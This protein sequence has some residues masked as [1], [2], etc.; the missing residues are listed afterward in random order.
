MGSKTCAPFVLNLLRNTMQ[1][2]DA[3][4]KKVQRNYKKCSTGK[5]EDVECICVMLCYSKNQASKSST[6]V[7]LLLLMVTINNNMFS[8]CFCALDAAEHHNLIF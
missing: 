3:N 8:I 2:D 7:G 6:R 5:K 4:D 1:S